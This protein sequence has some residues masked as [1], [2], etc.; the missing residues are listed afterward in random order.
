MVTI[1]DPEK[2]I[3]FMNIKDLGE[4][5]AAFYTSLLESVSGKPTARRIGEIFVEFKVNVQAN[6]CSNLWVPSYDNLCT[7]PDKSGLDFFT[8]F[9][10]S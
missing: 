4:V 1:K 8:T 7:R 10:T 5:H 3:I 2:K 6:R 9:K